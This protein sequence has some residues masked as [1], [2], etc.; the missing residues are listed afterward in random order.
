MKRPA[1]FFD[2]DNTLIVS[3]GYLGDPAQVMLVDGAADAVAKA[4]QYGFKVFTISNQSG[5]ARG[6]FTEDAVRA[7]NA[8]MDEMLQRAN[9]SALIQGHEYCPHH[10]D[11]TVESYRLD[12]ED[13]KPR[14]GMLK[15]LAQKYNLDLY[16]SWVVGDAPRDIEAGKAAG[17]RTIL[18]H[19][20]NL[21]ASPSAS[22]ASAVTPD[23]TVSSLREAVNI[24]AKEAFKPTSAPTPRIIDAYSNGFTAT[25]ATFTSA[26]A[27]GNGKSHHVTTNASG[28]AAVAEAEGDASDATSTAD[29]SSTAVSADDLSTTTA[30][31]SLNES[32]PETHVPLASFSD[33]EEAPREEEEV[34]PEAASDYRSNLPIMREIEAPPAAAAAAA[35]AAAEPEATTTIPTPAATPVTTTHSTAPSAMTT[36]TVP[37][38]TATPV[39]S[40]IVH[41]I[42]ATRLESLTQEILTELRRRREESTTDFSVTKLLAGIVQILALGT[43]IFAFFYR[44]TP[45]TFQSLTLLAIALQTFTTS[46]L[47]MGSQR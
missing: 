28:S 15:R 2:R 20:P 32:A 40:N 6:L 37:T 22:E 12:C 1:V 9:G 43:L 36:T 34:A 23:Y 45:T 44:D 18:F 30:D 14:P 47:L 17:C 29:S 19:D 24:I 5:V 39:Q 8:R 38:T 13:R 46:L 21:P 33:E 25:A 16:R 35:A 31:D 3:D 26:G 11:A 7:V 42:T 41:Q 27:N 10:P 4:R